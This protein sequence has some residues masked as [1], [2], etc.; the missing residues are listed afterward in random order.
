MEN[1]N[2]EI[3]DCHAINIYDFPIHAINVKSEMEIE[4]DSIERN[5]IIH[6]DRCVSNLIL[7]GLNTANT[8]NRV[9]LRGGLIYTFV[10]IDSDSDLKKI[11]IVGGIILGIIVLIVYVTDKGHK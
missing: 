9:H 3:S 4:Q 8:V 5:T 10:N 11:F 6:H 1:I 7:S 2:S